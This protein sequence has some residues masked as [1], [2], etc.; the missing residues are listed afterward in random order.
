[1][2]NLEQLL[3]GML[4]LITE[5][6]LAYLVYSGSGTL[7][8]KVLITPESKTAFESGD[9]DFFSEFFKLKNQG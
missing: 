2:K 6:K 8:G 9:W 7:L 3:A 1:M 4:G 5:T